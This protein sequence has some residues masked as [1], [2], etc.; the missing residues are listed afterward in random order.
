[1]VSAA[2]KAAGCTTAP[3]AAR[4]AIDAPRAAA[5]SYW[6]ADP[7]AGVQLECSSDRAVR[8]DLADV[9]LVQTNHCLDEAHAACESEPVSDSSRS[10]LERI[11]QLLEAGMD[12][13]DSAREVMM[14]RKGGSLAINRYPED[15]EPTTTN[16]CLVGI[17]AD[18]RLEACRGPADRGKWLTL[19]F[20]RGN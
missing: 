14:D 18:R 8:R 17:P 15:G 16:A 12:D 3:A 9:P 6:Y 2:Q 1:M 10:R 5:H 11:G 4:I 20:E 19:E 7:V 13:A